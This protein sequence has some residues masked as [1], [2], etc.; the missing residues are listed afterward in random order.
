MRK[1][2]LC[3][4]MSILV[5][6]F[7]LSC[8]KSEKPQP[9]EIPQEP[10]QKA[11]SQLLVTLDGKI[12]DWGSIEPLWNEGG[13]AGRG[14]FE[15]N[16]DIQQVYFKNDSQYLYVFMRIS[17]TIED[18]FK[19]SPTGDIIGDLFLDLDNNPSTGSNAIEGREEEKYKGYEARVHLPVGVITS[20]GKSSPYVVYEVYTH[21]GGFYGINTADRQDTMSEGALISHGPDGIEFAVRLDILKLAL[22][23]T[24]RVMLAEHSHFS[25]EE[26]YSVAQLMLSAPGNKP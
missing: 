17:P 2:G 11:A 1:F 5:I 16:I 21:E 4:L 22:P 20:G 12:Q 23:A 14:A 24:I 3:I 10:V 26:G 15:S 18:R 9:V 7:S 13:M 8:K 19:K 6:L 25:K